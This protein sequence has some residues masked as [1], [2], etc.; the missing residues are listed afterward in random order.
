[1]FDPQNMNWSHE[2]RKKIEICVDSNKALLDPAIMLVGY[3]PGA[4]QKSTL[5]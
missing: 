2:D 1:M 3:Q 4:P 5:V